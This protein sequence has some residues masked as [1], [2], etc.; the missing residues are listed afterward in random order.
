MLMAIF[1]L[2]SLATKQNR[3]PSPLPPPLYEVLPNVLH[4]E[5]LSP[6]RRLGICICIKASSVLKYVH[7]QI[8][9]SMNKHSS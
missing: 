9:E 6:R 8:G 4:L 7:A 3:L 2:K 1:L 5:I